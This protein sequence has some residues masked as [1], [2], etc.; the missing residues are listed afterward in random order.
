MECGLIGFDSNNTKLKGLPIINIDSNPY[1]TYEMEFTVPKEAS[2]AIIFCYR[3]G[4]PATRYAF[5]DNIK[6]IEVAS[7]APAPAPVISAIS[8][9]DIG[10]TSAKV[11]YTT[12]IDAD[13]KIEYGESKNYGLVKTNSSLQK[14]HSH[15]ISALRPDTLYHFRVRSVSAYGR[16][17]V[18][19]DKTF[20][21]LAP[22]PPAPTA[23]G[24]LVLNSSF[25]SGWTIGRFGTM[26]ALF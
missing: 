8:S 14:G 20:K 15:T 2:K 25:E 5:V 12:D 24:N 11:S 17:S 4:G 16:E 19:E 3:Y 23:D 7:E 18:S 1:K 10:Q 13:S 21:T 26:E 22:E 6:L 9:G